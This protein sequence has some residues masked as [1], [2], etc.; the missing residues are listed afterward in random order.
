M[1]NFF[2]NS[3]NANL[4]SSIFTASDD[5]FLNIFLSLFN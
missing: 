1:Q 2:W 3:Y 4:T 5:I